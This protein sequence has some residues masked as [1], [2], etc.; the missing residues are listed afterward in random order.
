MA[1]VAKVDDLSSD[2][3]KVISACILLKMQSVSRAAKGETNSDIAELRRKEYSALQ[4]LL[5]RFS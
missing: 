4:V 3:R 2:D 1:T 5:G